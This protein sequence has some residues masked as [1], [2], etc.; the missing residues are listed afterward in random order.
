MVSSPPLCGSSGCYWTAVFNNQTAPTEETNRQWAPAPTGLTPHTQ[1]RAW[2]LRREAI[3]SD[4][5]QLQK[6]TRLD[7]GAVQ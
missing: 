6:A 1:R 2:R 4:G 3:A 5:N 7:L